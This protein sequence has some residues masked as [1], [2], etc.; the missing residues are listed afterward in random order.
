M[1]TILLDADHSSC[2]Y[3][4]LP[5]DNSVPSYSIMPI[6]QWNQVKYGV[7][8]PPPIDSACTPHIRCGFITG[9]PLLLPLHRC[10]Q[11]AVIFNFLSRLYSTCI[12]DTSS[13]KVSLRSQCPSPPGL[14]HVRVAFC[15]HAHAV[16]RTIL[17]KKAL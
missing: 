10:A 16:A 7:S 9:K 5:I 11:G 14:L 2:F 8:L 12:T 6:K 3:L 4:A 13:H 17:Q 15:V 1:T